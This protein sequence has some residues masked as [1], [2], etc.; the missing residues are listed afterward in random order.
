MPIT[1]KEI[2]VFIVSSIGSALEFYDF[3]IFV[4]F[5][6]IISKHYFAAVTS[7]FLKLLYVY[8]IFATGYLVRPTGGIILGHF[9]DKYARKKVFFFTILIM[10]FSTLFIG[11]LPTYSSIRNNSANAAS[12]FQIVPRLFFGR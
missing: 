4:L 1:K 12:F 5:A 3:I 6:S 9:G 7:P 8:I 2:R 11:I 10:A